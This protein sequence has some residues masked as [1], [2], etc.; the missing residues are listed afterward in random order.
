MPLGEL[1]HWIVAL[2]FPAV[3]FWTAEASNYLAYRDYPHDTSGTPFPTWNMPKM[4]QGYLGETF[5][6][7]LRIAPIPLSLSGLIWMFKTFPWWLVFVFVILG[8]LLGKK[9]YQRVMLRPLEKPSMFFL[10]V[11]LAFILG[12]AG[13]LVLHWIAWFH[14]RPA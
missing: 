12:D 10:P 8:V 2:L 13:F 14:L 1:P 3:A 11:A 9:V 7:V 4:F 6:A 5:L